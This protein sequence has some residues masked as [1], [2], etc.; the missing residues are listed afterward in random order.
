MS[1]PE[2][3]LD[4]RPDPGPTWAGYLVGVYLFCVAAFG[5]AEGSVLLIVPQVVGVALVGYAVY[6]ILRRFA[7]RIPLE[8]GFY[9]LMGLWAALTRYIGSR[10]GEGL[11]PSLGTL[12]KIVV[13]AL[14]CAQLI[15]TESDLLV[16]LKMFVLSILVV[17]AQNMGDLGYLSMMG[18]ITEEDRF[19]GTL[20]NAN[21]AAIFALTVV[22]ASV[23]LLLRSGRRG[24]PFLRGAWYALPI[25]LSLV[26]IY[27]S[28]SKK[29]LIGLALLVLFVTRLWYKRQ[30]QTVLRKGLVVLASAA[31]IGIVGYFIYTSP[32][33]FRM[34][35]LFQGVTNA[36]DMA[37]WD[38]AR[39]ALDVWLM[40]WKAFFV[41]VG[42]DNF[43]TFSSIGTYA[44]STPLELLASCGLI[45]L[46]LFL[47]F[48]WLLVRKFIRLYRTAAEAGAKSLFFAIDIFLGIY[49]FF[50][51]TAVI[52][53]S[54]E[55]IPILAC[56]AG[57]GQSQLQLRADTGEADISGEPTAQ[58][59]PGDGHD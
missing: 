30:A 22:W 9:A 4:R 50:M 24:R 41:G 10:G 52:H 37:R 46:S 14:A 32:F 5:F 23:V 18:T 44:H 34:Q 6:D 28:G 17:F 26:I 33:F 3:T 59:G 51:I 12:L 58:A 25:G 53:D 2:S 8:I 47:A 11:T 16:A 57:F 15:K 20:S 43:W 42:Y 49:V 48:L 35:Q 19:A 13:A 45:G 31:L 27:Y 55:L 1:L 56:L 21:T 40:N 54:K 39:D 36:S 29:G 7:I 38:L